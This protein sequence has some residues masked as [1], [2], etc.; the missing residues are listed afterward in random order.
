MATSTHDLVST[1]T[2]TT[3]RDLV[4]GA[5]GQAVVEFMSYGC[6]HC[7]AIEPIVQEVAEKMASTQKFYRVNVALDPD[8][9]LGYQIDGTPTF[10]MFLDGVEVG[11]VEGPI[12]TVENVL[13]M[14]TEPYFR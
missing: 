6:S 3:F 9:E 7:H 8:L 13:T 10:V 4:L 1:V 12:P 2:G 11:R 5:R 14:V